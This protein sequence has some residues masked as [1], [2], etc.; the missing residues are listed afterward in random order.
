MRGP[1][2]RPSDTAALVRKGLSRGYVQKMEWDH[3]TSA[4]PDQ[5]G[6]MSPRGA[7]LANPTVGDG[8]L[9]GAMSE[10]ARSSK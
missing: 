7:Y 10:L 8:C 1:K 2:G 9:P 6:V 4:R 3:P 5:P